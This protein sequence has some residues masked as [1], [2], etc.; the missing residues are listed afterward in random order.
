MTQ[1]FLQNNFP[2]LQNHIDVSQLLS[3]RRD[4]SLTTLSE[5]IIF[6][7]PIFQYLNHERLCTIL[8]KCNEVVG[9][10]V[11]E[12]Q[13]DRVCVCPRSMVNAALQLEA[14]SVILAHNH[15]S[16]DPAPSQADICYTK[17]ITS[18]FRALNIALL[19][20]VIFGSHDFMS[21]RQ[22]ALL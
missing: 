16:G 13:R 17:R 3:A 1:L 9:L 18:L 5:V 4:R 22:K 2:V 15:P 21:F 11:A 10:V 19:D 7:R 8:L 20:H 12:G 14:D 6:L